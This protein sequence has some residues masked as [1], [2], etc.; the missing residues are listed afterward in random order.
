MISHGEN[1]RPDDFENDSLKSRVAELT[2]LCEVSRALQR[3]FNQT[4]ALY[5]ILVGVSAGPGLGFNRAFLLLVDEKERTLKGRMA[6]GPD[7]PEAASVIWAQLRGK[8]KSLGDLLSALD[9][10]ALRLDARVNEIAA[11]FN[12]PL[13]DP[14]HPLIRIMR[15]HEVARAQNGYFAPHGLAVDPQT[16]QLLGCDEFAVAPLFLAQRDLGLLIADNAIMRSPIANTNLR[17]LQIFAQEAGAAIWNTL[18]YQEL[19]EHIRLQEEA[20]A[21]LRINQERLIQAERLS[22]MGKMAALL[23][24]EI[25]TP[26]VSIGGFARRLLRATPPDDSRREEMEIIVSEVARLEYLVREVLGFSRISQPVRETCDVNALVES[27]VTHMQESI[28]QNQ[29]RTQ[30]D[31][32]P[33]LRPASMDESQ[34]RQAIMNLVTNALDAMPSGGT[35][36]LSTAADGDYLEIGVHDT[37]AG[38]IKEHYSKLFTPFF[39]TKSSGTGL[40]LVM[41]SQ[42]VDHHRG[43]LRFDSRPGKG[44]SFHI[45][46]PFG[47]DSAETP[48][49]LSPPGKREE[50]DP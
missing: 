19:V 11:Q 18:L 26:L 29:V 43:S 36:S 21:E 50:V 37:G 31:L 42:V 45:R 49:S 39:T 5:T 17:M 24:H 12:I 25:R 46:L 27:V 8:H 48:A 10:S 13:S 28:R 22:T 23:A 2:I 7:S 30:L 4:K 34:M 6:V 33:G 32:S 38:I 20:N 3:T 16:S 15:S 40:G 35:L 41:V 1:S 9:E 44:T 14:S 47:Q